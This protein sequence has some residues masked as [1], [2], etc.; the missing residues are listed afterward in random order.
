[1]GTKKKLVLPEE[2]PVLE[3]KQDFDVTIEFIECESYD[4][5]LAEFVRLMAKV[6][7]E[8]VGRLDV[9]LEETGETTFYQDYAAARS[10][11]VAVQKARRA[12]EAAERSENALEEV[13]VLA[14]RLQ[15]SLA[16]L[17]DPGENPSVAASKSAKKK[18][19]AFERELAQFELRV[20]EIFE[21]T[22]VSTEGLRGQDGS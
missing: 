1:M 15:K 5:H 18:M 20:A 9:I 7:S 8:Y 2:I 21:G 12:V 4:A 3:T 22:G 17:T 6:V 11:K 13:R 16:E 10:A 14:A 19:A